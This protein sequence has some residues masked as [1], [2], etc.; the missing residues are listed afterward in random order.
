M[1][2]DMIND[3]IGE[4]L[5]LLKKDLTSIKS[6][7]S[8]SLHGRFYAHKKH[9][10]LNKSSLHPRY[11]YSHKKHEVLNKRLHKKH[12]NKYKSSLKYT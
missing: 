3:G 7:K 10:S 8:D 2:S 1:L 4:V 12:T 5:Y 9:K 6:I 11:F